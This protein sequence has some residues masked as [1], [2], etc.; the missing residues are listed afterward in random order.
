VASRAELFTLGVKMVVQSGSFVSLCV[1]VV[2]QSVFCAF[3]SELVWFAFAL[4][5]H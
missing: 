1:K 3:R 2:L 4:Y 5:E